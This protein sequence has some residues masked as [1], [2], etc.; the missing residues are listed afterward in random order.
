MPYAL[1]AYNSTIHTA[2]GPTPFELVSG[3]TDSKDPMRLILAQAYTQYVNA[4]QNNTQALYTSIREENQKL[5]ENII[6]KRNKNRNSKDPLLGSQVYRKTETRGG[7]LKIPLVELEIYDY[8]QLFPI[9]I[10][11]NNSNYLIHLPYKP[12]LTRNEF[13]Y[14]YMEDICTEIDSEEYICKGSNKLPI[15]KEAPCAV[16][17]IN[18]KKKALSCENFEVKIK[19]IESTRISDG[20]WIVTVPEEELAIIECPNSKE[21]LPIHG[22]YVLE[23]VPECTV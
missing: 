7:K 14:I 4:H 15:T 9:P 11:M 16:Q 22:S 19:K 1:I 17:L 3:H 20:K 8:Y 18:F 10:P 21:N 12:F 6:G 5:K 13:S 2:T 23:S